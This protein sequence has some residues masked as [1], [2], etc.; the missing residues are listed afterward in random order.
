MDEETQRAVA[1]LLAITER[2]EI[3]NNTRYQDYGRSLA[4]ETVLHFTPRLPGHPQLHGVLSHSSTRP[5]DLHGMQPVSD[6][7]VN[8]RCVFVTLCDRWLTVSSCVVCQGGGRWR[9]TVRSEC[10]GNS[11][12]GKRGRHRMR[13]GNEHLLSITKKASRKPRGVRRHW[14]ASWKALWLVWRHECKFF[15]FDVRYDDVTWQPWSCLFVC[16]RSRTIY[17]N[18]L[19]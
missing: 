11:C 4:N 1:D 10:H 5:S 6:P 13:H 7:A 9:H 8:R 14:M 3:E 17:S 18:S 12:R 19:W 2:H 16:F 15:W